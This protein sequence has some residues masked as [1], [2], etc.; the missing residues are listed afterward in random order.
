MK[1]HLILLTTGILFLFNNAIALPE[2]G[3]YPLSE[4]KKLDLKKAGLK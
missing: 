1:K 2:E 3:M 4:I